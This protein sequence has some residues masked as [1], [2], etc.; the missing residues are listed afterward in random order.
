[1]LYYD[2]SYSSSGHDSVEENPFNYRVASRNILDWGWNNK[3]IGINWQWIVSPKSI[4]RTHLTRSRFN[5]LIG[6]YDYDSEEYDYGNDLIDNYVSEKNFEII[7]RVEDTSIR[8]EITLIAD[9]GNTILAGL[10]KKDLRFNLGWVRWGSIADE[11]TSVAYRDTS[12]WIE[13]RPSEYALFVEYEG[14]IIYRT[15]LRIGLRMSHYSLHDNANLEPR[16][17]LKYLWTSNLAL[18][19][20]WGQ[21][22]QY[23]TTANPNDENLRLINLWVPVPPDRPAPR[24]EHT[25]G[26]IEYIYN[27]IN[28]RLEVYRKTLLNLLY[29]KDAYLFLKG[30]SA[31][32]S[33]V[34]VLSEFYPAQAKVSG[35][36]FLISKPSGRVSGWL[37][38]TYSHTLWHTDDIGWYSPNYDRTHTINL[39]AGLQLNEKWHVGTA[40]SYA[41][42]NPYTPVVARYSPYQHTWYTEDELP[43]YSELSEEFIVGE[44][45]SIRYPSYHRWDVSFIRRTPWREQGTKEIYISIMN[46]FNRANVLGYVYSRKTDNSTGD[47]LGIERWVIPMLPI[48]PTIGVRYEF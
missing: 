6:S 25:I 32:D 18:T 9:Q 14:M 34:E 1:M 5:Y 31:G 48:L 29:M 43:N 3:A 47:D 20:G 24:A 2:D 17:G 42:G 13:H 33:P 8:S 22:Y 28:I 16:F 19:F 38:Y 41:T 4:L 46:I 27:N 35:L 7:D 15:I 26:G 44:K 21:Y 36:E 30:K 11:D 12:L 40:Y 23:L 45:N 10:E 37:G 39:V